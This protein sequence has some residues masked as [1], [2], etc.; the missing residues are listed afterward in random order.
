MTGREKIVVYT[1][2]GLYGLWYGVLRGVNAVKVVFENLSLVSINEGS[3]TFNLSILIHNPLWVD[4]V[5]NDIVGDIAIM[6][7]PCAVVNYPVN[8]RLYGGKTSRL[9]VNFDVFLADLGDALYQNIMTGDIETL[10]M[11]FNGYVTIKGVRIPIDKE[12]TIK[13]IIRR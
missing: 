11:N 8:Q 1:L 12:F 13:E 5:V 3:L 6:N 4:V 10:I 9:Q 2:L 7:I